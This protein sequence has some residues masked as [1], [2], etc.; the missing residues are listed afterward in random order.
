MTS[1]DASRLAAPDWRPRFFTLWTGQAFSLFGSQLVQ[2]ALIWHLT[3]QTNSGTVLALASLAGLLPQVFVSPL[4]GTLVD[5]WNRRTVM[6]VADA[7]VAVS[8]AALIGLL[9]VNRLEI[10][11]IY[12]ALFVRAVGGGFHQSAYG[13]SVVLMVPKDQLA[14]IQGLN[15]SL[16]GGLDIAAAPL[17]A[18]LLRWLP[19]PAVLGIDV[20]TAALA[21]APLLVYTLP[22]PERRGGGARPS[23]LR[24]ML[25]GLR[26]V[27]AWPGL[28]A[29]LVMV[30]FINFLFVPAASLTPLLVTRHFG[31]EALHLGWLNAALGAGVIVGGAVLGVWG[32]FKRRVMT[33]QL[34]LVGLGV[35]NALVALTPARAFPL[36]VAAMLLAGVM[37]PI[38]N[39]SYGAILQATIAPEMQGRVFALV[40]SLAM[41]LG[42][43]G[44]LLAGPLADAAGVRV[45]FYV[46]GGVCALL[47]VAGLLIPA[48][49]S[50]E[51]TPST[52]GEQTHA[53]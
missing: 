17:G 29:V 3:E 18:L 23:V 2:F 14:R 43:L 15:Q 1:T 51:K 44:L 36:A 52:K 32:G 21:I 38:V 49:M 9:V 5:R 48:V 6:I 39:G 12:A 28:M 33:A 13:A 24:D 11:H 4:I 46:A 20:L 8:T 45:W 22:Q 30:A 27:L 26:Y 7:V 19:L 37:T 35:F 34:G 41:G 53:A 42:P 25:D 40:L 10:W 31:G 50:I 47:G 16:R